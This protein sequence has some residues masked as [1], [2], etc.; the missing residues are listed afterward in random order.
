MYTISTELRSSLEATLLHSF[1]AQTVSILD[2]Y[3][4]LPLNTA[5]IVT[6]WECAARGQV[7]SRRCDWNWFTEIDESLYRLN[8]STVL[9]RF[10]KLDF[11]Q[12][13]VYTLTQS[14][15]SSID[16]FDRYEIMFR[17]YCNDG[18]CARLPY[19]SVHNLA[20]GS[21]AVLH[22]KDPHK[23]PASNCDLKLNN[24]SYLTNSCADCMPALFFALDALATIQSSLELCTVLLAERNW[25]EKCILNTTG[26][27]LNQ[28]LAAM[29]TR[30]L[31]LVNT[32]QSALTP[33]V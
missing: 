30:W 16:F 6:F 7:W 3:N 26:P 29:L 33:Q 19:L 18:D 32:S 12:G 28:T 21:F 13:S 5:L 9:Q 20:T 14:K 2:K 1:Q 15:S 11:L 24:F 10:L 8:A 4:L 31:M 17:V 22:C 23:C 27:I 25:K